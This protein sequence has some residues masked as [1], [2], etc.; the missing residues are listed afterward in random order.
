MF[1]II[2]QRL[3]EQ[4]TNSTCFIALRRLRT[5]RLM[6]ARAQVHS[7]DHIIAFKNYTT[8]SSSDHLNNTLVFAP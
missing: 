5:R 2:H 1:L 6:C 3:S 8:S 4:R 7:L